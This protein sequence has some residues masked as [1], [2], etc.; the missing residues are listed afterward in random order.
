MFRRSFLAGFGI[1]FLLLLIPACS[2]SKPTK[3]VPTYPNDPAP[4]PK[5]AGKAG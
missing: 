5:P 3:S 4:V 1:F 2:D